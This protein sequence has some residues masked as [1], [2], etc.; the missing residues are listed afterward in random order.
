[1][2]AG[3]ALVGAGAATTLLGSVMIAGGSP[4]KQQ[5][6]MAQE[7][8]RNYLLAGEMTPV[9]EEIVSEIRAQADAMSVKEVTEATNSEI[10]LG[11][12][13]FAQNQI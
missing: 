6:Q 4:C 2:A 11:L 7:D 8:M 12:W 10:V 1:M 5:I 13:S 9:L 3:P